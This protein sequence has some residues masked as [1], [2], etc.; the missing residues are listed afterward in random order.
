M[1]II[2]VSG[3]QGSGKSYI[4]QKI[5][6]TICLDTDDIMYA[7]KTLIDKSQKTR[8]KIPQTWNSVQ[9][10][11]KKKIINII[12]SHKDKET[13]ILVFVGTTFSG[14]IPQVNY[15]FFIK[16]EDFELVFRRLVKRE[17]DKIVKNKHD[18]IKVI[19]T[20]KDVNEIED[21]IERKS[22]ISTQFP[23]YYK[24]I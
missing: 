4:C 1:I 9:K 21:M 18:I 13:Q 24:R 10:V 23:P 22:G 5:N 8:K 3:V 15:K 14:E 19:N 16:I 12:E 17:L 20:E 2:H 7:S 6:K 11:M